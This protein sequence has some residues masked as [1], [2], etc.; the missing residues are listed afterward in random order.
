MSKVFVR[1]T[2]ADGQ[3]VSVTAAHELA[4][5]LVDPGVQLGA[6]GPDG[7]TWY[8]YEMSDAVEREEFTVNGIAMSNF[9]YPAWFEA[10]RRPG[11]A[12]FD[13]LGTC[14]RAFEIRPGGYMPVFRNGS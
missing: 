3:K 4:E 2:L 10:F 8:A 7:Q 6:I 11:S 1:T 14:K 12:R 5:M 9:V 13:H